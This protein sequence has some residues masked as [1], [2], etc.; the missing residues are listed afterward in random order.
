MEGG[1]A[2]AA[3]FLNDR[4]VDTIALFFAPTLLG[5][6]AIPAVGDLGIKK[7]AHAIRLKD[8]KARMIGKDLLIEAKP[9]LL[10]F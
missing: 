10:S 1:S 5:A 6:E 8:M 3:S 7:A 9:D 2:V 4:K